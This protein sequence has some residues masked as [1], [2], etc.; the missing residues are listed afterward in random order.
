MYQVGVLHGFTDNLVTFTIMLFNHFC[1]TRNIFTTIG[2]MV[3]FVNRQNICA[4]RSG[5]S[6]SRRKNP[7]QI[8]QVQIP[9]SCDVHATHAALIKIRRLVKAFVIQAA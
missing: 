4:N 2:R 3:R 5:V 9:S 6:N 7:S 1:I 8:Y